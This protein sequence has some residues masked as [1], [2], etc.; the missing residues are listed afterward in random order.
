MNVTD[1]RLTFK[2]DTILDPR[3][4]EL[5]R[6]R[7]ACWGAAAADW[8][9]F[10]VGDGDMAEGPFFRKQDEFCFVLPKKEPPR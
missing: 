9:A 5:R 8:G 6:L 7:T 1:I 10:N 3:D 4:A 2:G